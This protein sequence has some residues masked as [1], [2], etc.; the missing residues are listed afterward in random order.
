MGYM[1][2]I[3]KVMD[4]FKN[5][6]MEESITSIVDYDPSI[7]GPMENL[8]SKQFEYLTEAYHRGYYDDRRKITIGE[9]SEG[10][11]VSAPSYML[12]LIR[13][14]KNLIRGSMDR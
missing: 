12:T 13:A 9:L 10:K 11:G 2:D 8:T 6:R 3:R 14:M 1:E 5:I 4:L 7:S